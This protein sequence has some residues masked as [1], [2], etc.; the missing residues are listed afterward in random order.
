MI[1]ISFTIEWEIKENKKQTN[2]NI[3]SLCV[4]QL[5]SAIVLAY[6][7]QNAHSYS[8][9]SQ[10]SSFTSY[11]VNQASGICASYQAAG[12]KN[13]FCLSVSCTFNVSSL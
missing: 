11:S 9:L 7:D 4:I 6:C 1:Q 10:Q 3:I 12:D 5:H 8:K 2:E 13:T